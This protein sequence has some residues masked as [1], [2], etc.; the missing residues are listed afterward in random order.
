MT[1]IELRD[2][3]TSA[4]SGIARPVSAMADDR[5][6]SLD[7]IRGIAVL[8]ILFANITAF[9]QPYMAY[10]W[11]PALI[12][13]A[14][15]ADNAMWLFQFVLVDG[16]FRALF[17]LLFGAGLYL[18]MEHAWA[19]GASR[20]LQFRR[21]AFLLVFGLVHYFLIWNGDIL[22]TYAIWGMVALLTL[23]WQAE[24]QLKVGLTALF[25]GT[26]AITASMGL[27]YA[28]AHV[29][30]LNRLLPQETRDE[31]ANTASRALQKGELDL[32]IYRD[33]SYADFVARQFADWGQLWG[34]ISFAGL[35]ETIGL[36]LIGCALYRMGFFTGGFARSGLL[37]WGWAGVLSGMALSLAV[38]LKPYLEGFEFFL[39]LFVFNGL[40]RAPNLLTAFGLLALLV[41][42]SPAAAQTRL[43]KRFMAAGRMAFSNYLGTS[44]LMMPVFHGW[45]LGLFGRLDRLELLGV[46]ALV[47]AL[48]LWWSTIW[49]ARFRHGPLEWLWRCLTYGRIFPFRR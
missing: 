15:S 38:G 49:L 48:M 36:I 33:G 8:G 37:R 1:Q 3:D 6:A 39:T 23:K 10:F 14:S 45:G 44:I 11:P 4:Y 20:W 21:L 25:F 32:S 30:G 13:G 29:A 5:I 42:W 12:G 35:S 22:T 41:A 27:S 43:G 40:G 17:T 31:I 19:R 26:L 18:F 28:A 24:T 9:G 16:K 47:W 34:E 7:F 2:G 46:V